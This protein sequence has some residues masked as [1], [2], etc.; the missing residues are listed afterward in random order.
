VFCITAVCAP[1]ILRLWL[2]P[3]FARASAETLRILT[4]GLL[5]GWLAGLAATYLRAV[6]RPDLPTKI[7]LVVTLPELL[8]MFYLVRAYGIVGAAWTFTGIHSL[9]A[10]IILSRC[11]AISGVPTKAGL[12]RTRN[13]V[14]LLTGFTGLLYLLYQTASYSRWLQVGSMATAIAAMM[15]ALWN[16]ALNH[17]EQE[18]IGGLLQESSHM[19]ERW[20]N[21]L[22][23]RSSKANKGFSQL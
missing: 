18:L 20:L 7:R 2:G 10:L 23:A 1:T 22:A 3:T 11:A 14:G 17:R 9:N 16:F 4:I 19:A 13:S 8:I 15:V 5:V 6:G 12:R 21:P